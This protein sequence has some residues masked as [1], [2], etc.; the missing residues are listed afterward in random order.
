[1]QQT[2]NNL[3]THLYTK[4]STLWDSVGS[5]DPLEY[6][7]KKLLKNLQRRVLFTSLLDWNQPWGSQGRI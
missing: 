4:F 7:E 6:V 5:T 2:S 3:H 1:L